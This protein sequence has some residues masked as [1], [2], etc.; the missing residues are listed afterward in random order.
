MRTARFYAMLA[1]GYAADATWVLH[2]A[3]ARLHGLTV[4]AYRAAGESWWAGEMR[5]NLDELTTEGIEP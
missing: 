4:T 2:W 3:T 5:A 1:A